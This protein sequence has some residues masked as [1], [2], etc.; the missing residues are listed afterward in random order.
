M[1]VRNAPMTVTG[2][3]TIS[4]PIA[5]IASSRVLA[6]ESIALDRTVPDVHATQASQTTC[7]LCTGSI[8][9]VCEVSVMCGSRETDQPGKFA[10]ILQQLIWQGLAKMILLKPHSQFP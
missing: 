6:T 5:V 8:C 1:I 3:A 7:V 10:A 9:C 4:I 2:T